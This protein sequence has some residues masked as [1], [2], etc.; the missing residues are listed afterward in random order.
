MG[1][2]S[3][4]LVNTF[5]LGTKV[6]FPTSLPPPLSSSVSAS[7][8]VRLLD[9]Q[10]EAAGLWGWPVKYGRLF[11]SE[12]VGTALLVAIGCSFVV[13]DFAPGSPVPHLVA[14][15]ALR[16]ALTG[17]LFGTTGGLI[18][19]SPVGRES[20]AHINPI[21]SLAFWL[22]GTLTFPVTLGYVIAQMAGAVLGTFP[23]LL[24]GR[25]AQSVHMAATTLGPLGPVAGLAGEIGATALLTLGLFVFLGHPRLR[26]YTP[27][28][29]P[30]L[31]AF[32]VWIEAPLSGTSTN[33]ARSFGPALV[34][35]VWSGLW[36]D[37]CGPLCGM[38]L[39]LLLL[40]LPGLRTLREDVAKLYHF[41]W[42]PS[43]L[44]SAPVKTLETGIT[45]AWASS[46]HRPG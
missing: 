10:A 6:P 13:V 25:L 45:R 39:G 26:R 2:P 46:R 4:H 27:G 33:P 15:A 44:L 14:S 16:R 12:L 36:V 3:P 37:I 30:L 28:L 1:C 43:G 18:A 32:L 11:L 24:W 40:S 35:G 41:H 34:G 22:R 7:C 9:S 17:F 8:P 31:Y 21:V 20:G 19:L 5:G 29:F 38:G 42:D 23:L